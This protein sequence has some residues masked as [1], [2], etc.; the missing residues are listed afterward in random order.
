MLAF[1]HI[2][3]NLPNEKDVFKSNANGED[4]E[5]ILSNARTLAETVFGISQDFFR[6]IVEIRRGLVRVS[7]DA[8]KEGRDAKLVMTNYTSTVRDIYH[9]YEQTT[10]TITRIIL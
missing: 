4:K 8:K 3:G 7:K 6:E 10:L 9:D 1:F 2:D 5:L